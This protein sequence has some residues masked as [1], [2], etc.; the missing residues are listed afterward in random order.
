MSDSAD[1][2]DRSDEGRDGAIGSGRGGAC[3]NKTS[4]YAVCSVNTYTSPSVSALRAYA[5]EAPD[6]GMAPTR[7]KHPPRGMGPKVVVVVDDESAPDTSR[8]RGD[9]FFFP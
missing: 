5:D 9:P 3:R 4:R 7:G 6:G 2:S 1:L 8:G